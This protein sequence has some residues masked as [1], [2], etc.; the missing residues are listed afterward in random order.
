MPASR[1]WAIPSR[2]GSFTPITTLAIPARTMAEFVAWLRKEPGRVTYASTGVGQSTHLS[3]VWMLQLLN[4]QAIHV[5][6]RGSGPML[7]EVIAGRVDL[8]VDNLPSS[9]GHIRDG[10]LRALAVTGEKRAPA[11]PELPAARRADAV[12]VRR[13]RRRVQCCSPGRARYQ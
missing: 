12:V 9:L 5:P 2:V 8:A 1:R 7:T 3:P 10:R 4:A 11:L 13:R 6:F